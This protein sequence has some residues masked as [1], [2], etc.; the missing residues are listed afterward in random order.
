MKY[1]MEPIMCTIAHNIANVLIRAEPFAIT[2]EPGLKL[3]KPSLSPQQLCFHKH[4]WLDSSWVKNLK[5][6][7][8]KISIKRLS[9]S[10]SV[11]AACWGA[12]SELA[13]PWSCLLK[14]QTQTWSRRNSGQQWPQH[15]PTLL[16]A[17]TLTSYSLSSQMTGVSSNSLVFD[18]DLKADGFP[19]VQALLETELPKKWSFFATPE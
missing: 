19:P 15:V 2:F 14:G 1:V 4:G 8:I 6:L 7:T 9:V 13:W 16:F 5:K 18:E 10:V 17:G 12:S 3:Q 11:S